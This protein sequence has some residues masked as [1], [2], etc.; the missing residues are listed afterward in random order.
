MC[1]CPAHDDHRPSLHVS[2][3]NN[4]K[5]VFYCHAGCSQEAVIS[6]LKRIGVWPNAHE[7]QT[8]LHTNSRDQ[9]DDES[10]GSHEAAIILRAAGKAGAGRPTD[11]LRGRG[12]NIMPPNAKILPANEALSLLRKNFPAMV[13]TINDDTCLLGAHVTFLTRDTKAKCAMDT[14]RPSVRQDEGWLRSIIKNIRNCSQQ[15]ADHR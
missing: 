7:R 14:P 12:I 15:A 5:P 13:C 1:R 4:G 8:K 9:A 10:N 3:G 11:Y 2:D 6:Q